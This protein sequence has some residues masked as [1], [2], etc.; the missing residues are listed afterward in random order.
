MV[1]DIQSLL[2]D[3]IYVQ[4][5]DNGLADNVSVCTLIDRHLHQTR[6]CIEGLG[7]MMIIIRSEMQWIRMKMSMRVDKFNRGMKW[8]LCRGEVPM[9]METL[10][11]DWF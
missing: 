7:A 1:S 10:M 2:P 3:I 8:V 5:V 4:V 11:S 9:H 6:A